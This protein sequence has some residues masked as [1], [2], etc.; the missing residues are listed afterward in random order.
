[1]LNPLTFG[2]ISGRLGVLKSWGLP[3]PIS[4]TKYGAKGGFLLDVS[5]RVAGIPRGPGRSYEREYN[6]G[7]F[8]APNSNT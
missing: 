8:I 3:R 5:V 2:K 6:S 1:M 7:F 4:A